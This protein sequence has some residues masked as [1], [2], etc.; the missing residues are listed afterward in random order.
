MSLWPR[1]HYRS[2]AYY[3]FK[4]NMHQTTF[5][6]TLQITVDYKNE[7]NNMSLSYGFFLLLT[8]PP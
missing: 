7:T 1:K 2:S 6:Y 3:L 8:F 5:M 4:V